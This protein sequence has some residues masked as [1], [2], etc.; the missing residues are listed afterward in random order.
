MRCYFKVTLCAQLTQ[1][2]FIGTKDERKFLDGAFV[3][4]RTVIKAEE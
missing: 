3:T 4:E 2:C 1:S